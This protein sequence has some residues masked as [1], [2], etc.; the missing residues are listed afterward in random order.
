MRSLVDVGNVLSL[1]VVGESVI[2]SGLCMLV[3]WFDDL[4]IIVLPKSEVVVV[5]KGNSV[6]VGS[7]TLGR[8]RGRCDGIGGINGSDGGDC[9]DVVVMCGEALG[10]TVPGSQRFL[11]RVIYLR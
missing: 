3:L 7:G 9:C 5:G 10:A 6:L 2:M 4:P 1:I 11:H 8:C